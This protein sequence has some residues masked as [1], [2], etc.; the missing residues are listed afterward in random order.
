MATLLKRWTVGKRIMAIVTLYTVCSAGVVVFLVSKLANKDIAFTQL[1]LTGNRFQ[2][3]LERALIAVQ[4]HKVVSAELPSLVLGDKTRAETDASQAFSDLAKA[5]AEMGYSLQFTTQALAAK[6]RDRALTSK[7]CDEWKQ[8]LQQPATL[9][10][11]EKD[12]LH[13]Q[14]VSDIQLMITHM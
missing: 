6:E 3:P 11:E 4:Q 9:T 2:E 14:L 12:A 13:S 5:D 10:A 7:V 8:L 1:E